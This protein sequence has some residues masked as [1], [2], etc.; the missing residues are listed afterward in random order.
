MDNKKGNVI[1]VWI[2]IA[3]MISIPLLLTFAI[4]KIIMFLIPSLIFTAGNLISLYDISS[5]LMIS[6]MMIIT[7]K[8]K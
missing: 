5:V 4:Y 8:K 7:V 2:I 3:I 1:L 6:T